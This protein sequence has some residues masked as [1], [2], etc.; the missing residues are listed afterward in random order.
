MIELCYTRESSLS[1][2]HKIASA[3]IK[4]SVTCEKNLSLLNELRTIIIL[5]S[6]LLLDTTMQQQQQESALAQTTKEDDDF[7]TY[8]NYTHSIRIQLSS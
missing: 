2:S 5:V 7:L 6:L 4:S 3:I 8:E 1:L